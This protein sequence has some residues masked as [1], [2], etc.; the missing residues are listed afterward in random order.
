MKDKQRFDQRHN[1]L[2]VFFKRPDNDQAKED[3][4]YHYVIFTH[5]GFHMPYFGSIYENIGQGFGVPQES[6][7]K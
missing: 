1:L 5:V 7:N 6:S 4:R 2:A 3:E